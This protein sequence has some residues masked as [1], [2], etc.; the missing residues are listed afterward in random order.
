MIKLIVKQDDTLIDYLQKLH[1]S[2][3]TINEIKGIDLYKACNK[4]EII[5]FSLDDVNTTIPYDHKIDIC[6]EDN[7]ILL[8]NKEAG[9]LVHSDGSSNEALDNMVSF[10]FK[11]KNINDNFYHVN[12][13]DRDTSGIVIYAKN[14]LVENYMN[15]LIEHHLVKKDYL[16][17]VNG[18]VRPLKGKIEQ[19]IS[20]DRH[21]SKK[22]IVNKSGK[23]AVTFYKVIGTTDK[24]SLLSI[25]IETGRTHQIRVHFA[26]IGHPIVGDELYGTKDSF[27]HLVAYRVS[28][29]PFNENSIETYCLKY[30]KWATKA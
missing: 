28:F 23:K 26:Y 11:S 2:K 15:Y 8:V 7:D 12:R 5:S 21:N 29:I 9:V 25:N 24:D 27:L 20:R 3:K 4:N 1:I 30:P 19:P 22:Y 18:V 17:L 16:A 14:L 13:I 6:Y 10:Y